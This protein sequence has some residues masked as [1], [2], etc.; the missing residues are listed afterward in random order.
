MA[1]IGYN[2]NDNMVIH[3]NHL[4]DD[5]IINNFTSIKQSDETVELQEVTLV[6]SNNPFILVSQLLIEEDHLSLETMN[7]LAKLC[8]STYNVV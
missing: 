1:D 2:N 4:N 6:N 3:D 7:K 5:D 8:R